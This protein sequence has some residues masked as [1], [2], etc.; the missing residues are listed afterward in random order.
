M[1]SYNNRQMYTYTVLRHPCLVNG[2]GKQLE[3]R[4]A[5]CINHGRLVPALLGKDLIET[6]NRG[7]PTAEYPAAL[8]AAVE[9]VNEQL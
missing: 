7:Y 5:I 1:S 3:T 9:A 8:R 2:C 4:P 6:W